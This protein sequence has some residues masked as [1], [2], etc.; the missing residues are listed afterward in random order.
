MLNLSSFNFCLSIFFYIYFFFHSIYTLQNKGEAYWT[1]SD[2]LKAMNP[3]FDNDRKIKT[4]SGFK[5]LGFSDLLV[6]EIV[7][8]T[9]RVNYGQ[10]LKVHKFVGEL[11]CLLLY[12]SVRELS[13]HVA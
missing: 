9:I 7:A 1:V 4:E 11:I 13:F 3:E 2:L 6:D 8:S 10:D 12:F 5:K